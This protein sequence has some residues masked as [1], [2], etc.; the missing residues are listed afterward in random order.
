MAPARNRPPIGIN[1]NIPI[2]DQRDLRKVAQ[3]AY[4]A[5]DQA[6][7]AT[8]GLSSRVSQTESSITQLQQ[9]VK[10]QIQTCG[11]VGTS[12]PGAGTYTIGAKRTIGGKAGTITIDNQG[13]I[14]KI[15]QAS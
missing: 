3:V 4:D 12:G 6:S 11:S 2:P 10:T 13:R 9:A 7:A 14:T 5:Q 8:A 15:Q 1:P